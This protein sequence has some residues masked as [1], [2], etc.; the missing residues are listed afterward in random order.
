M[1]TKRFLA[2]LTRHAVFIGAMTAVIVL[3]TAI[4][5]LQRDDRYRATAVAE[6]QA[7]VSDDGTISL[8]GTLTARERAVTIS[9]LGGTRAVKDRARRNAGDEAFAGVSCGVTQ[10]SQSEFLSVSCEGTN[11]EAVAAAANATALALRAE[12]EAQRL[13]RIEELSRV[14]EQQIRRLQN[15]GVDPASFPTQPGFPNYREVE[16]IQEASV[17]SSPFSPN[18]TRAIA[19]ALLLGLILNSALAVLLEFAQDKP[20]EISDVERTVGEPIL[21]TIPTIKRRS[22]AV[23]GEFASDP[24]ADEAE[25]R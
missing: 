18:V 22:Q 13:A 16:L 6:V 15:L 23:G 17:P 24:R 5:T 2:V 12:L 21:G 20:H 4:F 25:R 10:Q 1:T 19:I 3:V 8:Q 14:Y 7:P 9:R 11:P